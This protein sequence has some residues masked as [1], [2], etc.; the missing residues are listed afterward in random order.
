MASFISDLP[1]RSAYPVDQETVIREKSASALSATGA[2]TAIAFDQGYDLLVVINAAAYSG[3][4]AGTAQW[5]I[6]VEASADNSTFVVLRSFILDGTAQQFDTAISKQEMSGY[7]YITTKAT[8]TGS[9]G[10]LTYGSL[11]PGC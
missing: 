5:T 3:Y 9:P 4:A 1:L 8:K 7:S 6:T 2:E 11:I 10:N